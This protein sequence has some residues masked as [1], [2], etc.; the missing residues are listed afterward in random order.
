MALSWCSKLIIHGILV[1]VGCYGVVQ[2]A[3]LRTWWLHCQ[4]NLVEV[5]GG[6]ILNLIN[7]LTIETLCR[8]ELILQVIYRWQFHIKLF[9][10]STQLFPVF[11]I[12]LFLFHLRHSPKVLVWVPDFIFVCGE[13]ILLGKL[14]LY[15]LEAGI[16]ENFQNLIFIMINFLTISSWSPSCFLFIFLNNAFIFLNDC[17]MVPLHVCLLLW[18]KV[19]ILIII[20]F[21]SWTIFFLFQL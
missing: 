16:L 12:Y 7:P 14:D 4:C 18:N 5:I 10:L 20:G 19:S 13:W 21:K 9:I 1:K 17:N 11:S 2:G 6:V 8:F 3:C 15:L